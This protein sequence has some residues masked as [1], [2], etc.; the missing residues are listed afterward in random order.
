MSKRHYARVN[1]WVMLVIYSPLLL[2]V[3]GVE[4]FFARKIQLNRRLGEEDDDELQEWEVMA[5][6]VDYN[7]SGDM[8]WKQSVQKTRNFIEADETLAEVKDLKKQVAELSATVTALVNPGNNG[9]NQVQNIVRTG[10]VQPEGSLLDSA[11]PE[12]SGPSDPD[13]GQTNDG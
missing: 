12:F 13:E 7:T 10:T 8:E 2:F 1:D 11:P 3:A 6:D 5:E 9:G 4:S